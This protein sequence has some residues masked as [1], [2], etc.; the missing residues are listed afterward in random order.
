V[1]DGSECAAAIEGGGR[2]GGKW[3]KDKDFEI[4]CNHNERPNTALPTKKWLIML[5]VTH[6]FSPVCV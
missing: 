2:G 1:Y 4:G 3:R 5:H 6:H